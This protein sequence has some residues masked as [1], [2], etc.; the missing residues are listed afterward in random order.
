[1]IIVARDRPMAATRLMDTFA[2]KF[3]TLAAYPELGYRCD[4][5]SPGLRCFAAG[6]YVV[7]YQPIEGGVQIVRV[8]HGSQDQTLL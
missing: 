2:A 1:M 8:M 7:F 4:A 6:S 3:Q 5:V